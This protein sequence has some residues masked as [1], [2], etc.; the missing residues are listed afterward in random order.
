[1]AIRTRVMNGTALGIGQNSSIT[2]S[3]WP[4]L[5]ASALVSSKYLTKI[6]G[7]ADDFS[8]GSRLAHRCH[9]PLVNFTQMSHR[10]RLYPTDIQSQGLSGH[11]SDARYVWNLA[12]E[13]ANLYNPAWGPTPGPTSRQKQLAEARKN[14]WLGQGSS[15]V[16]QQAL[17]D[18][19]K[20]L[21]NWWQG[22]H[23][24]PTWR[25]AGINEGFCVRDV[26]VVK[27]NGK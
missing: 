23:R 7:Q 10:Y 5:Q 1:M 3:T 20:A 22:T 24:R 6:G 11:C 13:Q 19:E 26:K 8:R 27:Q 21:K 15:S 25:K 14:S 16:Q 17:R 9:T 18:F 2:A 12:L 4:F